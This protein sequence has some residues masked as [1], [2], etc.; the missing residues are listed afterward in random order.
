MNSFGVQIVNGTLEITSFFRKCFM[1]QVIKKSGFDFR[2][3]AKIG[4]SSE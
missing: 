1:S 3:A 2:A 4:A